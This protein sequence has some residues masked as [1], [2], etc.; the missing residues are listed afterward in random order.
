MRISAKFSLAALTLCLTLAACLFAAIPA[1]AQRG[2]PVSTTPKDTSRRIALV[3]GNGA[4]KDAPLRNPANDAKDLARALKGLGFEVTQLSNL[5]QS[6]MKRAIDQ[7]GRK[8]RQGGVGFFF[9]AGHG[10]QVNGRNYLFPIGAVIN[11]EADVEY[12]C[13][14]AGRVLAKMETANNFMNIMVLDACRNNPYAA[15]FRS[16]SKGLASMNAPRGTII[17]YA[18]SPGQRAADGQGRNSPFTA[19]LLKN[20]AAPGLDAVDCLQNVQVDVVK[21]TDGKQSPWLGLSPIEGKF[22]FKLG[23]SQVQPPAQP[24][25]STPAK[26]VQMSGGPDSQADQRKAEIGRL[27]A[28][29]DALFNAGKLTTPKGAN[30]LERYNQVLFLQPLNRKADEGLRNIIG[31]YVEWAKSRLKVEDYAKAEQFLSRA[32]KVREGDGRVLAL[33][34]ELRKAKETAESRNAKAETERR[35]KA[36]EQA[37]IEAARK[38]RERRETERKRR[39]AASAAE[40]SSD[41]RY[42]KS[43]KG[44]ITDSRT[45]LQWYVGPDRDTNWY[46]AKKWVEGLTVAGGG[47]RMPS[48]SELKGIRQKGASSNGPKYLPPIFKPASWWV[49]SGEAGGTSSA[50]GFP[51][52]RVKGYWDRPQ[53]RHRNDGRVFAVRP[54]PQTTISPKPNTVANSKMETPKTTNAAGRSSDGRFTR[55]SDGVITDSRTGLQWYVGPDRNTNWYD[56]KKWVEGLTVADG[57]W[58]MP[59]LSELKGISQKGARSNYPKYLPTI[60]KSTGWWVCSGKTRGS[61][62]AWLFAFSHNV[63]AWGDRNNGNRG[64]AFAVRSRR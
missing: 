37:R 34:D 1:L 24:P 61:S 16:G 51:F 30:A 10:A 48:R 44:V 25:A 50:W 58:R 15:G 41:G 26:P 43:S 32:E 13:V 40:R 8:I 23:K 19:S 46:D 7:F 20:I 14:D 53:S 5:R 54:V 9:F 60:F 49:W 27:L 33:R 28:E 47:W 38:E 35:R 63:D 64:R 21:R 18:A 31:K 6:Q 17:A 11:G 3:I 2:I 22:F 39:E 62:Q 42:T 57:G 52:D 36:E 56:A 45:G 59:S 4:Y 29:A 12:E 55:N